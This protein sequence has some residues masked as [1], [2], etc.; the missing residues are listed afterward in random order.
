MDW[1]KVL[2]PLSVEMLADIDSVGGGK[3]RTKVLR[4]LISAGLDQLRGVRDDVPLLA[5]QEVLGRLREAA[6]E[7]P[8]DT[9]PVVSAPLIESSWG[10][11][12]AKNDIDFVAV[13]EAVVYKS[14]WGL[15]RRGKPEFIGE[16][17]AD[18]NPMSDEA[19]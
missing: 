16:T 6:A 14:E 11:T 8:A 17:D 13:Q 18:G 12:P 3:P 1:V 19:S 4:E 9:T 2:L 10:T 15:D 5:R 7:V